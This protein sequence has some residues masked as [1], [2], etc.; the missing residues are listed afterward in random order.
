MRTVRSYRFLLL[1]FGLVAAACSGSPT[2]VPIRFRIRI[3]PTV[4]P[5]TVTV[6]PGGSAT[7][8]V[9]VTR[10]AGVTGPI[11]VTASGAPAGVTISSLTVDSARTT[12]TL[13]IQA[14]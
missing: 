2:G 4:S 3:T 12:G 13:S 9:V 1:I 10:P 8:N 7:V 6:V 11:T 14:L 5:S